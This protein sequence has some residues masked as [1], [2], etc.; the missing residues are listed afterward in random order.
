MKGLICNFVALIERLVTSL[1]AVKS[2]VNIVYSKEHES[3][4][5]FFDGHRCVIEKSSSLHSSRCHLSKSLT[6]MSFLLGTFK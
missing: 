2:E 1:K 5:L 3:K 4:N 6:Q